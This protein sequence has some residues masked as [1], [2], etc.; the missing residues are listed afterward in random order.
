[1]T[2]ISRQN[3]LHSWSV[4]YSH[5]YCSSHSPLFFCLSQSLPRCVSRRRELMFRRWRSSRLGGSIWIRRGSVVR[6]WAV[7]ICRG[8]SSVATPVC[9]CPVSPPCRNPSWKWSFAIRPTLMGSVRRSACSI[10]ARFSLRSCWNCSIFIFLRFILEIA[11]EVVSL[12]LEKIALEEP[13]QIWSSGKPFLFRIPIE[14]ALES[15]P[16]FGVL[17][18]FFLSLLFVYSSN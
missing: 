13:P 5:S 11:I 15:G 10:S 9:R 2:P 7:R 4:Y 16:R 12:H 14:I 1:M 17:V 3:S 6:T 8:V 18:S